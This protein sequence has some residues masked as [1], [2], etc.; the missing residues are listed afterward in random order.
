[1]GPSALFPVG[2]GGGGLRG[3]RAVDDAG[4]RRPREFGLALRWAH[5]PV[6]V[7]VVSL[8]AFARIYLRAGR[9]WLAWTVFGVRTL[10]LLLNFGP[11][12]NLNYREISA[13]RHLQFLGETVSVARGRAQSLDAGRSS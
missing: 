10:A 6:W 4:A 12:P 2:G 3:L 8:V 1:M 13:L 9:L 7:V 11:A 5:V